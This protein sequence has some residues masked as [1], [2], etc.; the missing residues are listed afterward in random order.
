MALMPAVLCVSAQER[1][2]DSSGQ[3][4][5]PLQQRPADA[6]PSALEQ[7]L[8]ELE[9]KGLVRILRGPEGAVAIEIVPVVM[10]TT[11]V[12]TVTIEASASASTGTVSGQRSWG[13]AGVN[14]TPALGVRL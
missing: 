9:E 13:A 1:L 3:A 10:E 4:R 11:A 2:N 7:K 14:R 8:E 6:R 5:P 12:P